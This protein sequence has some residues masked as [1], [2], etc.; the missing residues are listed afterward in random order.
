MIIAILAVIRL[1]ADIVHEGIISAN[2]GNYQ[3][4]AQQFK[5]ACDGENASGCYNLGFLYE[6]GQGVKQNYFK[7]KEFYGKACDGGVE[8]GCKDYSI[9]NKQGY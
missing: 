8:I 5:K 1:Q 9:L 3:M 7:A 2:H 6:N 4:A